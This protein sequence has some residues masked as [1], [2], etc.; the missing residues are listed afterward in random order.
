MGNVLKTCLDLRF[1]SRHR[2]LNAHWSSDHRCA[3]RW[4]LVRKVPL[5]ASC[6]SLEISRSV[7][8][9]DDDE[10]DAG[11]KGSS[12]AGWAVRA[13]AKACLQE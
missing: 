11:L 7:A 10:H 6:Y 3:D 4:S 12:M 8:Q 1:A 5:T 13:T 9:K 2:L